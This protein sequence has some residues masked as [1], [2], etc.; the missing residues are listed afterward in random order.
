MDDLTTTLRA[1]DRNAAP[2][3]WEEIGHRARGV[4]VSPVPQAW[5]GSRA[6]NR[7]SRLATIFVALA[8]GVAGSVFVVRAF[9]GTD[10]SVRSSG[11]GPLPPSPTPSTVQMGCDNAVGGNLPPG[12]KDVSVISGRIAFVWLPHVEMFPSGPGT[13][14]HARGSKVLILVKD[15]SQ[16]TVSIAEADR[17]MASLNYPPVS[18]QNRDGS[19]RLDQGTDSVTFTAC[20]GS[21]QSWGMATQFIGGVLATG[22]MCLHLV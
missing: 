2:D 17:D 16:V 14:R 6:G 20:T 10:R 22:P 12:W 4:G 5:P 15:G 19:Y 8:V 9:D 3:L 13:E 11:S 18:P 1:L 7:G 21:T